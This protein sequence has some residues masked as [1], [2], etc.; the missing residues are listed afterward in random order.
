MACFFTY[1]AQIRS[2]NSFDPKIAPEL[3]RRI[4]REGH[5]LGNHTYSHA[6]PR[7]LSPPL[8]RREVYRAGY[9]LYALTGRFPGWFRPPFGSLTAPMPGRV[10][11][12]LVAKDDQV[13]A[14]EPLLIIEALKMESRVPAPIDGKITAILAGEGDNVKTDETLIQIE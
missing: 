4:A 9:I 1:F 7:L 2:T 6:H 14:G 5:T 3:I 10:V 8:A 11:K 12:I 13:K